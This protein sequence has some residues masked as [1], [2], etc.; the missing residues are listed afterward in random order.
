[1]GYVELSVPTPMQ[2]QEWD[3]DRTF[4]VERSYMSRTRRCSFPLSI[5]LDSSYWRLHLLF[6]T[7]KDFP[8]AE[9]RVPRQEVE[10]LCNKL[11]RSQDLEH[12]KG[13]KDAEELSAKKKGKIKQTLNFNKKEIKAYAKALLVFGVEFNKDKTI[14][15]AT[16]VGKDPH[17]QNQLIETLDHMYLD[18]ADSAKRRVGFSVCGEGDCW[19]YST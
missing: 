2:G 3:N 1:M 18:I 7:T 11:E 15:W 17:F 5:P 16:F 14:N 13:D 19:I 9:V 8:G 6:R 4:P 12:Q 10:S